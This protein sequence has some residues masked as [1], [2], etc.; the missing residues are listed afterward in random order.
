MG[1]RK[2]ADHPIVRYVRSLDGEYF[3]PRE[4]AEALGCSTTTLVNL[5]KQYPD[6]RLGPTHRAHYGEVLLTLY[7]PAR[8]ERIRRFLARQRGEEL[9]YQ[10]ASGKLF[11]VDEYHERHAEHMRMKDYRARAAEYRARGE[12]ALALAAERSA[13]QIERDLARGRRQRMRMTRP[14]S[15]QVT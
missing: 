11:T 7:T 6:E 15:S 8:M 2:Y 9:P 5:P 3:L 13:K 1:K 14:A 12:K 10:L 4:V